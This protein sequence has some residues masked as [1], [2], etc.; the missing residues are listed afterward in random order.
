MMPRDYGMMLVAR[1]NA[2]LPDAS[3]SQVATTSASDRPT[4]FRASRTCYPGSRSGPKSRYNIPQRHRTDD[5]TDVPRLAQEL[6]PSSPRP[7]TSGETTD[8][9]SGAGKSLFSRVVDRHLADRSWI[10]PDNDAHGVLVLGTKGCG[11]TSMI[12]SLIATVTGAFPSR[13][14]MDLQ[15]K[16]AIMSTHGQGYELPVDQDVR[17]GNT[18]KAAKMVFTDTNPCA[19]NTKDGNPLCV[20]VSPHSSQHTN[21][22]PSWMRMTLRGGSY[23]HYGVVVVLDALAPPLWEDDA[24][25]RDLARLIAVLRRTEYT[26]VLAVTKLYRARETGRREKNYGVDHKKEVGKDPHIS[27]ETF[28]SRYIGKTCAAIQAKTKDN[29]WSFDPEGEKAVAFPLNNATIFDIPTWT[30]AGDFTKWQEKRGTTELPNLKYFTSQMQKLLVAL[31]TQPPKEG[32][33][34]LS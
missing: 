8:V 23:P 3:V 2:L 4:L 20:A 11:K 19:P 9:F 32:D 13:H 25:C 10:Y 24:F 1:P 29:D 21:A 5:E 18:T 15:K 7:R 26:V 31:A 17:V 33:I 34:Q 30:S 28:V 27:Y 6:V 14:E 12:L 22:I 16:K